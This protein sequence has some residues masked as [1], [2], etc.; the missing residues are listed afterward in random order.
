MKPSI[1]LF[2]LACCAAHL[3]K[4]REIRDD[5]IHL[6]V[7][8]RLFDLRLRCFALGAIAAEHDYRRAHPGQFSGR[9]LTDA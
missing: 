2:E 7:S 9:D 5:Q 3:G 8:A 1:V 4:L 6:R